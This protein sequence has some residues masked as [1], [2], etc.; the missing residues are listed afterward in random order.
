MASNGGARCCRRAERQLRRLVEGRGARERPRLGEGRV[1]EV[2]VG[3]APVV[4]RLEVAELL[5]RTE[6][7][8]I[9]LPAEPTSAELDFE[10]LINEDSL[11]ML[12]ELEFYS[13]L[14]LDEVDGGGQSS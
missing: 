10:M 11:E 3:A 13:W 9:E 12:E 8:D 2:R 7:A 1:V 6:T 4:P 5:L 14:D